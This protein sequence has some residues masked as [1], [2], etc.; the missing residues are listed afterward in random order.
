MNNTSMWNKLQK[1]KYLKQ[2][3]QYF[4][5]TLSHLIYN[6]STNYKVQKKSIGRAYGG[7]RVAICRFWSEVMRE[8]VQVASCCWRDRVWNRLSVWSVYDSSEFS[9]RVRFYINYPAIRRISVSSN[10]EV[11][12]IIRLLCS[13]FTK[14]MIN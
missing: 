14:R 12:E 5:C 3:V 13:D 2:Y 8:G 10:A 4:V 11:S 6:E 1:L 7:V 9:G